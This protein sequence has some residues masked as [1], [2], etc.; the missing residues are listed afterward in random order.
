MLS[1]GR[2]DAFGRDEDHT[3]GRS[4]LPI[5]RAGAALRSS[6]PSTRAFPSKVWRVFQEHR[7]ATTDSF[8]TFAD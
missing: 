2:G 7:R 5:S 4:K 3:D 6:L 8:D 1:R